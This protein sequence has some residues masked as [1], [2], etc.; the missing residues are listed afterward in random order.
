MNK[1]ERFQAVREKKAPD[2]MPVW[3]RAMSQMIFGQGISLQ[4]VTGSDWYDSEK[5]TEA[6]LKSIKEID[7]DVAIPT[8]YDRGFGVP[9]LGG[10]ISIPKNF[11]LSVSPMDWPVKSKADWP[12][13]KKIIAS[14]DIKTFDPRMKGALEVIKNVSSQLGD[15][16]PLVPVFTVPTS[17]GMSLF[18]G[19]ETFLEDMAEDPEW[20]EEMCSVATDWAIDWIRAQ[21]E[22]GANSVTFAG[23]GIGVLMASPDMARRF[24][25]PFLNRIVETVK[26]EFN[27]GVWY[28]IHGNFLK[29][30]TYEYLTDLVKQVGIEGLH[31]DENHPENWIKE[32]VVEKLG[33]PA[34]IVVD[35]AIIAKGPAGKIKEEV[36]SRI[37]KVGDGIGIM[38][39]PSCQVLPHTPNDYFKA[40][41]DATHEYACYPL[42]R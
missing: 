2:Y 12:R 16:M 41:V 5:I 28:H 15:E 31:F 36:K 14:S 38:M 4:D 7:Y 3:P 11:G 18:R 22:A 29:P 8:Y 21:Y 39:A 19:N 27:Q 9:P 37:S 23:D 6:V 33:V 20:A 34:C 35:G 13:I 26:K 24:N 10:S 40:W 25:F 1:K 17:L 42:N 32:N 30:K